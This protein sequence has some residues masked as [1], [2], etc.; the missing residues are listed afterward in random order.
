MDWQQLFNIGAGAALGAIGWFA[1]QLWD[2]VDELKK[3]IGDLR[4]HVS[5]NYM[6]TEDIQRM[7]SRIENQLDKILDKVD[8]KAD[9]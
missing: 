6:R 3:E 4:L 2:A 9:K 8:Q 5:T 1:R 7:F